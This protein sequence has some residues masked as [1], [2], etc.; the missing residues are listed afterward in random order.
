M[1]RGAIPAHQT[2]ES[3]ADRAHLADTRA[4]A[5]DSS[6]PLVAV[7]HG[8]PRQVRSDDCQMA[9]WARV[10]NQQTQGSCTA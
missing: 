2:G 10:N 6:G 5:V 8:R 4:H 7:R 9:R 3:H 1:G